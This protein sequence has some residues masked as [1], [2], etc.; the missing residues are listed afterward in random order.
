MIAQPT[1]LKSSM[2]L[3]HNGDTWEDATH[4]LCV[5][6]SSRESKNLLTGEPVTWYTV[7][8]VITERATLEEKESGG[9]NSKSLERANIAF[10]NRFRELKKLPRLMITDKV[11]KIIN[12]LFL[13][14]KTHDITIIK[15]GKRFV[16]IEYSGQAY[17]L[18]RFGVLVKKTPTDNP[19]KFWYSFV[20]WN[21]IPFELCND[22]RDALAISSEFKKGAKDRSYYF[23]AVN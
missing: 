14:G 16:D 3:P 7:K 2:N 13:Q 9:F 15:R 12:P 5:Q 8:T 10:I 20:S 11:G 23:K 4:S 22:I 17:R 1:H 18:N 6:L 21:D 19:K